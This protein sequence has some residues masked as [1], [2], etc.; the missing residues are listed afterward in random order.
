MP[1]NQ[2]IPMPPVAIPATIKKWMWRIL[3]AI[4]IGAV[5]ALIVSIVH[6]KDPKR[7]KGA[8]SPPSHSSHA[9]LPLA[10]KPI[11]EWPTLTLPAKGK[12]E[13]PTPQPGMHAMVNGDKLLV[14]TV[15]RDGHECIRASEG[16]G[17]DVICPDGAVKVY[18]SNV[19]KEPNTISYAYV[20]K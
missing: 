1:S 12:V 5:I 16:T 19:M 18:V 8:T 3:I 11:A 10:S 7:E 17:A 9:E 6:N 15:Y 20:P 2:S 13:L 4:A 14:H